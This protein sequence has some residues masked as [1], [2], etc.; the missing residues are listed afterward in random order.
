MDNN[1]FFYSNITKLSGSISMP[2]NKAENAAVPVAVLSHGYGASRDE[3]GDFLVLS[4]ILNSMGIAVFRFDYRGCGCSDYPPG[5]MLCNNEWK[6]DLKNAVSFISSYKYIDEQKICL[7]GESMGAS[8]AI[9]AAA[10]DKRINCVI[11][12]SPIAD[13]YEWIKQNWVEN[14]NTEDFYLFLEEIETDK[15]R[16]SVYGQSNLLKMS[17]ALA[18]KQ[19]YLELIEEIHKNFDD[20]NFT[21]YIQLA[22]IA[23]ILEMK[24]VEV[25]KKISPRPLLLMAGEKDGIVPWKLNSQKLYNIADDVKKIVVCEE[26]DHGLLAE[27]TRQEVITEISKWL[28]KYL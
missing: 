12:L 5:R 8:T 18:Y 15:K 11:A 23:S 1:V 24:P 13:G 20:R 26:G 27:P 6:D 9:L 3:F 14:K 2:E 4:E 22:S 16:E 28:K 21:Y 7:I 10:E 17:D 25:I 19:R